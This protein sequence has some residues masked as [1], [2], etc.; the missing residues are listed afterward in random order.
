VLGAA[1]EDLGTLRRFVRAS[2]QLTH[3]D[4]KAY[5][6]AFAAALAAWCAKRGLGGREAF[7]GTYRSLGGTDS[8]E[9]FDALLA[10]AEQSLAAREP[11]E[12]F[13]EHL[14]CRQRVSGYVYRT[15]PV[16]LHCWLSH[17]RDFRLAVMT[18][19]RCGGDTDTTAAIVGAV[20]GSG[21]GRSGIPPEWLGRLWE[22]P[23]SVGWMG[24]LAEAAGNAVTTGQPQRPPRVFPVVGLARNA[25]F[26]AV[27][28]GHV[29]RRL[30][31]PF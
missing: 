21:L 24:R 31:P 9:E 15:V 16:A 28:L 17:P 7:F 4:P 5:H 14:G 10:K 30:L 12:V 26:L 3:T 18:V 20:V 25:L 19:I 23:R 11:T 27:V 8:S 22:W 29:A 2:T 13:A 6:G 1:I